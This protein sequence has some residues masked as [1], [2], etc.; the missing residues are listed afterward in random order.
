MLRVEDMDGGIVASLVNFGCHPVSIYPHLNTAIS[1]DYPAYTTK[2]VEEMEGGICLYALG[3]AGNIVP[4]QR[5]VKPR[6]QLGK[7][8]GGEALRKLQ[9]VDT[10]GDVTLK[11]LKKEVKFPAKKPSSSE[12]ATDADTT[13]YITTEIQVL[14]LGDIYIL[15]LPGETRETVEDTIRFA[16]ELKCDYASFNIF[17]PIFGTDARES[18]IEKG[19]LKSMELSHLDSSSDEL[20][21]ETPW[22]SSRDLTKLRKKAILSFYMRPGYIFRMI[23]SIRSFGNLKEYVKNGWALIKTVLKK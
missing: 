14:R 2:V 12:E 8:V 7:A 5:G 19:W 9:F 23:M 15:G 4:I 1:A 17:I 10:S 18:V 22:L 11:A 20:T 6:K 3:L 21:V 13:D 16:K